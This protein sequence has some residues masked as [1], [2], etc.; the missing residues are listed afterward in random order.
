MAI[1]VRLGSLY[2]KAAIALL[3]RFREGI[4]ALETAIGLDPQSNILYEGRAMLSLFQRRYEEASRLPDT[5][6]IRSNLLPRLHGHGPYVSA[7]GRF[8]EALA[9]LEKDR[10]LG[11]DVP[12]IL[13]E[14]SALLGGHAGACSLLARLHGR[15]R[16]EYISST[17]FVVVHLGL[18][19]RDEA[20]TW[21]EK[22]CDQRGMRMAILKVHPVDDELR[23]NSR[24]EAI[25]RRL[26]LG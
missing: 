17:Y 4:K 26:G 2:R 16:E 9:M 15:S 22:G 14:V 19:E 25:L 3:G 21:L 6:R 10:A 8:T 13:S 20:L 1:G 12:H 23:G 18:G 11:G 7:D 5:T 24:F